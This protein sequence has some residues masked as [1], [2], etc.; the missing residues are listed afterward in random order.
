MVNILTGDIGKD[1]QSL[2]QLIAIQISIVQIRELN[3]AIMIQL[4]LAIVKTNP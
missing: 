3:N 4:P 1:V 2:M